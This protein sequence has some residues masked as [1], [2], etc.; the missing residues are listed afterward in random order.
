VKPRFLDIRR[1]RWLTIAL[2]AP[3]LAGLPGCAA[4]PGAPTR[5]LLDAILARR[6]PYLAL[7]A[8]VQER[9]AQDFLR[10]DGW[11]LQQAIDRLRWPA[12]YGTRW[13]AW[14]NS[15]AGLAALE[16]AERHVVTAALLSTGYFSGAPAAGRYLGWPGGCIN[17]FARRDPA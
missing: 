6:A 3:L 13:L 15:S 16:R 11:R 7:D 9:F 1:R 4:R 8:A 17:P 2:A 5:R 12:L 10:H 14:V